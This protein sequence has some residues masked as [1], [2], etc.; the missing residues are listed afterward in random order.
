MHKDIP[1]E[2]ADLI[3]KLL[4]VDP[5]ARY[6][7][8][9]VIKHPWFRQDGWDDSRIKINKVGGTGVDISD[10]NDGEDGGKAE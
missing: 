6:T 8:A 7:I 9:D 4:Q 3:R 10:V 2:P 1:D 5:N